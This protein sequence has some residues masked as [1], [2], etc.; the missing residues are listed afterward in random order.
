MRTMAAIDTPLPTLGRHARVE[1]IMGMPM[2]IHVRAQDTARPEI[3]AAMT[4]AFTHLRAVDAVFSTWRADSQ[5]LRLQHGELSID[6][7]HP[8]LA[9]V[10]ELCL[11]A[12]EVTDGLFSAWRPGVGNTRAIFDP[13]GLVKGW[14]VVGAG[15]HLQVVDEISWCIGAGGDLAMGTGRGTQQG[16]PVWRVGIE[17]P[18]DRT[19]IADVVTLET[20]GLATSGAAARGGHVSDPRTGTEV[21]RPGSVTVTGPDLVRADVW[22]TAAWV[23]PERVARLIAERDTDTRSST[24]EAA[25]APRE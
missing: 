22:A 18:T 25:T 2:S 20:G 23:D 24:S 6:E 3:D 13:T 17:D 14:A 5:L 9:E 11:E 19:R 21:T 8:W 15:A 16:W 7:A 10:V 4:R 1:Q 12:E